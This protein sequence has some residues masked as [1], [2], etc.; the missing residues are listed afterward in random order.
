MN[1]IFISAAT[2]KSRD[3]VPPAGLVHRQSR[4]GAKFERVAW[5]VGVSITNV[6]RHQLPRL[7]FFPRF[8]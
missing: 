6:V 3:R 4:N 1:E 7:P 8:S 5:S 2:V